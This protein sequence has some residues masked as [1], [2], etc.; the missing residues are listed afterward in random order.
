MITIT[1]DETGQKFVGGH[2]AEIFELPT[3]TVRRASHVVPDNFWLRLAFQTIRACV[4]D[5]SR[6]AA[7]TRTWRCLWRVHVVA[8]GLD[9]NLGRYRDRNQAI[10]AEIGF[11]NQF[12][13]GE[14]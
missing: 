6:L 13:L 2:G 7:W 14:K 12:F 10:E 1:I 4:S 9:V 8:D 3:D 5:T 11:L